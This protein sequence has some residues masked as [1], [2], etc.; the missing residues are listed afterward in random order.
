MFRIQKE[1]FENAGDDARFLGHLV[2]NPGLM[3]KAKRK[4]AILHPLPRSSTYVLS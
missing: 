4:M 3:R 2:L 1:R